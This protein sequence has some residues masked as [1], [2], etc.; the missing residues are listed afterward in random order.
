M[1]RNLIWAASVVGVLGLVAI[2]WHILQPENDSPITVA[3]GTIRVYPRYPG[4]HGV[5]ITPDRR[6]CIVDLGN[7]RVRKI[8]IFAGTSDIGGDDTPQEGNWTIQPVDQ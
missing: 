8:R 6:T 3:D 2:L 1:R 5:F 4:N 7:R